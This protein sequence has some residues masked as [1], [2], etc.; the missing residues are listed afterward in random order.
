MPRPFSPRPPAIAPLVRGERARGRK[1]HK[2][3][4]A[5]M[6]R[7]RRGRVPGRQ[8]SLSGRD[9]SGGALSAGDGEPGFEVP[10]LAPSPIPGS[11]PMGECR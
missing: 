5:P 6:A 9:R 8:P 10:S 4:H 11:T 1:P 3:T 2:Q 7:A